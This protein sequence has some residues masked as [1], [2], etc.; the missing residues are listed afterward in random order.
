MCSSDLVQDVLVV[1]LL[2]ATVLILRAKHV[3]LGGKLLRTQI[4]QLTCALD[5][6]AVTGLLCANTLEPDLSALHSCLGS[7]NT[8]LLPLDT[9]LCTL[10]ARL[11]ALDTQTCTLHTC[12]ST[13]NTG[14][15][16][17]QT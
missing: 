17:L 15:L 16:A 14:L 8:C 1:R 11:C 9:G 3:L 4:A 5:G 2:L 13:L 7:L 12:L 6:L 10:N